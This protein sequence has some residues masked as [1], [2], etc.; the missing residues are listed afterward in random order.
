MQGAFTTK[1][2]WFTTN[3]ND[4]SNPQNTAQAT[5]R[6]LSE[7]NAALDNYINKLYRLCNFFMVS[8]GDKTNWNVLRPQK[9]LTGQNTGNK[10]RLKLI[11]FWTV[12]QKS[13]I[14]SLI[15]RLVILTILIRKTNLNFYS[16]RALVK[17]LSFSL[18]A[19]SSS[20][21]ALMTFKPGRFVAIFLTGNS[22]VSALGLDCRPSVR[23]VW[24]PVILR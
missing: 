17:L 15:F 19:L 13:G 9:A 2:V 21:D 16:Q 11:V 20:S 22:P 18:W 23:L 24:P 8:K 14:H 1:S 4:C 5:L 7:Q 3:S 12:L 10:K 6:L